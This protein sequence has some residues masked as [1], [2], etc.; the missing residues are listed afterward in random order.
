MPSPLP[1]TTP[2]PR[3]LS[4]ARAALAP[5]RFMTSPTFLGAARVPR[6]R[7]V[8]FVGNHTLMGVLDTP[9]LMLG[10]VEHTGHYPRSLADHFHF[11]VP[12]WRSLLA[13]FGAVPGS[14]EACRALMRER[15]SLLVFPG[16]GREVM[17]R[18]DEQYTLLWGDR[19]GFARLSRE[20][21]YTIVPVASV[22]AEECY[23]ILIDQG[24]I[25]GTALGRR[26]IARAPRRD[27]AFPTLVY[28]LGGSPLPIPQRFYFSFG[29]PIESE[30][31]RAWGDER[32]AITALRDRVKTALAAEIAELLR[33][34]ASAAR[35]KAT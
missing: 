30:P 19:S 3:A 29:E 34:R 32:A 2:E 25:A 9:L 6:D 18:R 22:G 20:A 7:P 27:V 4:A 14:R 8:M 11:R 35:A 23:R 15:A 16:G 5:W 28:G 17:K 33:R 26:L 10:I 21:G 1:W 24:D 13:H 12:L 31:Y